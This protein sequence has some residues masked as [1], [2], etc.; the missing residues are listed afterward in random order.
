[1]RV[2]MVSPG[3]NPIKGGTETVVR[4][5]SL[6]LNR[7]GVH[8]DIMTFNMNRK[9]DSKWRGEREE[10][11]GVTVFR[12]PA[13]NWMPVEHSPR[14]TLGIN[15][16]P[17]RFTGLMRQYD[18]IH[19]HELDFSFPLFSFFVNKP[20]IF[21]LHG[22]R[23]DY[24][25]RYYL[26]RLMLKH[27][28]DFYICITRQMEKD[29]IELG[30]DR[31]RIVHL[32]NAVDVELFH[33]DHEKEDNLI[34]YVGR[35]VPVKGLH[36]L[37]ESLRY[38]KEPVHLAIV[39][40]VGNFGY[41]EDIQK[42]IEKENQ[43]GKHKITY[44]GNIPQ[45]EVIKWYQKAAIFVLPSFWEAFP[46]VMLEALSCETPIIATPVGG[47]AE[48]I[49]NFKNGVLVPVGDAQKLA[50]AIQYLL[51]NEDIRIGLG[52]SGRKMVIRDFSIEALTKR[53]CSIYNGIVVSD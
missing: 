39:G 20:K 24:F 46:V 41:Y 6:E 26:S 35:I 43:K 32:P 11:D 2:L 15:L 27:V 1:V 25:K 22:I 29:L 49:R 9:W 23:V 3:F 16:V 50:N 28:T 36:V 10:I 13:L 5:L 40:P 31:S 14:V 19:F 7:I 52:Q 30:I 47:V 48:V 53:L 34:L 42:C 37:I 12:I 33:P 17:G 51:D 4:N 21:H 45:E 44:L 18:I 38:V 8:T